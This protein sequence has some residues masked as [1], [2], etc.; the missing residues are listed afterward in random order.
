MNGHAG[1][2]IFIVACYM[3]SYAEMTRREKYW[4]FVFIAAV[5]VATSVMDVT[6]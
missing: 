3:I 5:M 4:T 1:I 2:M 6:L